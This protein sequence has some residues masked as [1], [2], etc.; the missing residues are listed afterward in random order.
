MITVHNTDLMNAPFQGLEEI[1]QVYFIGIGGIGMSAVA[2]FFHSKGIKVSGYDK[3]ATVLTKDLEAEGITIHYEDN[4][5]QVPDADL[6]IYTPAIPADMQELQYCREKGMKVIKR[7]DVLQRIT[8]SSFNIC[9][10]GTHGKT[11]ITTMTAHLLRDSGFGCNAFLG[12][13]SANYQTN[14]WSH[15]RNVCVV[16]ADEYDRSFLK[17]TPSVAV[18]TSM[19]ADHLDI[20]GDARAVEQAFIDFAGKL[21]PGGWLIAR[22]GLKHE[23]ALKKQNYLSYGSA[24]SGAQAY[25][26]NVVM[27]EGGY[28][29]DVVI[30]DR[31]IKNLRLNMGGG[32]NVENMTAAI[33]VAVLLGI[34]D[35]AIKKAVSSFKGVKRRFEYI[36]RQ[37]DVVY[38]DDYAHHPEELKALTTGAFDLFSGH[39]NRLIFQ[40]HLFS[41]TRDF[42]AEFAAV[43]DT[44]D[45][46]W[47][48]PVYPARER[49]IP[50]V[51][52]EMLQERM[53]N[54]KVKVMQKEQ[55]LKT[56]EAEKK[57]G[58][59]PGL[60]ITAGA[61]DID[62]LVQPIREILIKK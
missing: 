19:D 6:V 62:T 14:F 44:A 29:F 48:L 57:S 20:Y 36:V 59:L 50:G 11:T 22:Q 12:G 33:A 47:L 2:R 15:E 9:I 58:S 1:Q 38:V 49:P 27:R 60:L 31:Q 23:A 4:P 13:V 43:L 51:S 61:G 21:L 52:S 37:N 42:A 18:I 32:H 46:V 8:K 24:H 35:E 16:E 45:E 17:L 5:D 39:R 34:A 40:P 56:L 55:V 28:D 3:T 53:K 7:S 54:T 30:G 41:R 10:A 25:A 26:A